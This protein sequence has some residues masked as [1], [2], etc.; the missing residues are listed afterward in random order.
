MSPPTDATTVPCTRCGV[1]LHRDKRNLHCLEQLDEGRRAGLAAAGVEV[2]KAFVHHDDYQCAEYLARRL[3]AVLRQDTSW[4]LDEVLRRL[5]MATRHLL[6]DHACDTLG[7]EE[8]RDAMLAAEEIVRFLHNDDVKGVAE[9]DPRLAALGMPSAPFGGSSSRALA[10]VML[11][12]HLDVRRDAAGPYAVQ[13]HPVAENDRRL[14]AAA[15]QA[16]NR[17]VIHP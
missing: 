4:P 6:C 8:I 10:A 2:I 11:L 17:M 15:V 12:G 16:L 3:N 1:A 5:A 14:Y 7:H 9:P 13:M